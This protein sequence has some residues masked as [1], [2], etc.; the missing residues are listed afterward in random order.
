MTQIVKAKKERKAKEFKPTDE[1]KR[2]LNY[3]MELLQPEDFKGKLGLTDLALRAG[4]SPLRLK[5][6]LRNERF[7]S[8]FYKEIDEI[9][10]LWAR[11]LAKDLFIKALSDETDTKT[12]MFLV[13]MFMEQPKVYEHKYSP[14]NVEVNKKETK[15]RKEDPLYTEYEEIKEPEENE[16]MDDMVSD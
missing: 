9:F 16:G 11:V 2:F 6:W 4:V 10:K 5:R 14:I 15:E 13:K 1:Q 7:K 12:K 8:W 3:V